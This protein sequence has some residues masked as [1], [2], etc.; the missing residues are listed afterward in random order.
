MFDGV[1]K[2]AIE[3]ALRENG[4]GRGTAKRI[5]SILVMVFEEINNAQGSSL[6]SPEGS[7]KEL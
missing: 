4:F 7:A 2:R 6:K 3:K 1:T 5:I